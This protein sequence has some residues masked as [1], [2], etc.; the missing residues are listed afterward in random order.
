MYRV[1]QLP[2]IEILKKIYYSLFQSKMTY[3]CMIWGYCRRSLFDCVQ[4]LHK[5]VI[6][7][8]CRAEYMA[9]A[10]PLYR[11]LGIMPLAEYVQFQTASW[12]LNWVN[13][14]THSLTDLIRMKRCTFNS[15]WI[16][17][18]NPR[19]NTTKYGEKGI[20]YHTIKTYTS[21]T[22]GKKN[23]LNIIQF[24]RRYKDVYSIDKEW[25]YTWLV[26]FWLVI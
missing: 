14:W 12:A 13:G 21:L 3:L 11:E 5:K 19:M 25:C 17:S 10:D 23:S 22:S 26:K 15:F 9:S 16:E 4:T 1:E 8:I 24:K 6:R 20:L 7:V 18:W 2:P